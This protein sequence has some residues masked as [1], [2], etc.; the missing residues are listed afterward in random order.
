M[1]IPWRM[2]DLL[3]M[4]ACMVTDGE[5][6]P[7]WPEPLV[8]GTH[9]VS[10]GIK[11]PADTSAGRQEDYEKLAD[12][13]GLLIKDDDRIFGLQNNSAKYFDDHAAPQRVGEYI[14]SCLTRHNP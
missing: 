13:I 10:G 8:D 6:E 5:F 12:K 11:R 1:C 7:Q 2:I 4:G 14:L 9:Y 3:C